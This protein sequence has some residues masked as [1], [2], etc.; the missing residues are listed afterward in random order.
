MDM[1]DPRIL[2]YLAELQGLDTG[3]EETSR[4][5][6]WARALRA[7]AMQGQGNSSAE[8]FGQRASVGPGWAGAVS[9]AVQG[10]LGGYMEGRADYA[11]R[12]RDKLRAEK[13]RQFLEMLQLQQA[14]ATPR[15]G[16]GRN[17]YGA[18]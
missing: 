10:G 3:D 15:G 17:P 14:G 9:Q 2:A 5:R 11:Q 18:R 8:M 7:R 1:N 13:A 4:K 12:E 16:Y 6:E